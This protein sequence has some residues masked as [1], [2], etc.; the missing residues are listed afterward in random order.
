[1]TRIQ[2]GSG[3]ENGNMIRINRSGR[4]T[5]LLRAC[6]AVMA[7]MLCALLPLANAAAQPAA[8]VQPGAWQITPE[9]AGSASLGYQLCFKTGSLDDLRVLLPR[10]TTPADCPAVSIWV[11]GD[12]LLWRLDCP[13]HAL[14]VDARY[15]LG[16]N[17]IDGTLVLQRGV[18]VVASTQT[19]KARRSGACVQ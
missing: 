4:A 5:Q 15:V 9:T 19:I 7:G 14:K 3:D 1:M 8:L 6:L 17:T 12:L 16:A 11:E 10:L 2:T 13:A 18:P